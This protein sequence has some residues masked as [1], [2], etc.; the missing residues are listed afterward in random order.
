MLGLLFVGPQ[1]WSEGSTVSVTALK[2]NSRSAFLICF[3]N[4]RNLCNLR[5][6]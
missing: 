1:L 5:I 6:P 2:E 3:P 4:L